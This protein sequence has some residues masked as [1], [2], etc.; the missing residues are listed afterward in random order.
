[1]IAEDTPKNAT[2]NP[3]LS[4]D[5]KLKIITAPQD[6]KSAIKIKEFIKNQNLKQSN[7]VMTIDEPAPNV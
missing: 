6:D 5:L 3:V 2:F 1:V 4:P 7:R